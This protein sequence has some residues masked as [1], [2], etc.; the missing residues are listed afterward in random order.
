M[1]SLRS[2]ARL[3]DAANDNDNNDDNCDFIGLH[4]TEV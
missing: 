3:S 4:Y 1:Q 2:T